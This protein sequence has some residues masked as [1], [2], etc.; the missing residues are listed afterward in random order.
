M[1]YSLK[2][3]KGLRCHLDDAC[4]IEPCHGCDTSPVDGRR[5]C[6]CPPGKTGIN[7]DTDVNE[8]QESK[9]ICFLHH[10]W[11]FIK[12][13]VQYVIKRKWKSVYSLK[14]KENQLCGILELKYSH[15]T[16]VIYFRFSVTLWTR[17]H[18]CQHARIFPMW[19]CP[20]I[21][22]RKMW[23]RHKGMCVKPVQKRRHLPGSSRLLRVCLHAR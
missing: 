18:L 23:T 22:R 21:R 15:V 10:S 5:V 3:F 19:L 7:C 11:I 17:W 8:C 1:W 16:P 6:D 4:Q 9:N 2:Y 20:R 14:V 12:Y 13:K